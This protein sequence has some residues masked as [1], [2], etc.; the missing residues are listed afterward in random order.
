MTKSPRK[1]VPDVGIE[2]GAACMP[3]ELASDRATAPGYNPLELDFSACTSPGT[4]SGS[5]LDSE[6]EGVHAIDVQ[7]LCANCFRRPEGIVLKRRTRCMLP[8]YCSVKC[9]RENWSEHKVAYSLIT[10]HRKTGKYNLC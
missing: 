3:S 4:S 5:E 1:N 2:L 10:A 8:F 9:Q 7:E 6:D